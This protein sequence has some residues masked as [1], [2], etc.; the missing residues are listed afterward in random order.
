MFYQSSSGT[1]RLLYA[2]I[3]TNR[4]SPTSS[5]G[6]DVIAQAAAQVANT[7]SSNTDYASATCMCVFNFS[8]N[9]LINFQITGT[10]TVYYN[11]GTA[12]IVLIRPL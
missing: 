9:A 10:G 2:K 1:N 6:T 12:T 11:G 8:A 4:S 5:E 7:D 3:R